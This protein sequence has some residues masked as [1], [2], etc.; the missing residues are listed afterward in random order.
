MSTARVMGEAPFGPANPETFFRA[1]QRNRRATWRMTTLCVVAAA[2][3]G[4]PLTLVLTPLL[5]AL[6]LAIAEVINYFSALPADFWQTATEL[7]KLVVRVADY[8]LNQRGVVDVN[9]MAIALVLVLLPGMALTL[10]LWVGVLALFRHGGVGGTLASLN[11]REPNP[12]DL[13]EL[14]LADA[15]QEMAIAAGLP[16]PKVMLIDSPGANAAAIGTSAE[17]AHLVLCRRL[18]NDL[19]REQLQAL[20]GHLVSSVGNGD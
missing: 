19:N 10:L 20:I 16:A 14:Q 6:T 3:M 13:K 9:E 7:S 12:S 5:Y 4:I 8:L 18:L 1:Q 2:L 11:A 15:V 17:D